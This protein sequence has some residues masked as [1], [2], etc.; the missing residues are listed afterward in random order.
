MSSCNEKQKH[1]EPESAQS[2]YA[3]NSVCNVLHRIKEQLTCD[4]TDGTVDTLKTGTLD[5]QVTGIATTFLATM[6]VIKQAKE[7]GL[8]LIITHEPTF[9][10]HWD[11]LEPLRDDIVQ[12]TKRAY[13]KK[14]EIAINC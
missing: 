11:D 13:I 10:N 14:H 2:K 7:K 6:K 8:K 9:Y 3:E 4:W 5:Q 1:A 12:K